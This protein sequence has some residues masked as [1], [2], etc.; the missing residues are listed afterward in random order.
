M[1]PE[2]RIERLIKTQKP[3]VQTDAHTDDR[4]LADSFAA[5]QETHAESAGKSSSLKPKLAAAAMIV[6]IVGLFLITHDR[7]QQKELPR[8]PVVTQSPAEMLTA[9]S[10]KMAY[11]RGGIEAVEKQCE[12]AF[13]MLGPRPVSLSVKEL[14]TEFNGS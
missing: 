1:N 10:L 8:S 9:I 2:Q 4:V 3:N 12:T 13:K 5:M 14:L 6:V 11:R 7:D